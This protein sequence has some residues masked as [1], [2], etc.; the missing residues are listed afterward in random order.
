MPL[1]VPATCL[2]PFCRNSFV[3]NLTIELGQGGTAT[4]TGCT[5]RC[6]KCGK[7]AAIMNGVYSLYKTVNQIVAGVDT[8]VLNRA[9]DFLRS[10]QN[11]QQPTEVTKQ[12][13]NTE[14][15]ELKSLWDL[16]P[17]KRSEAYPLIGILITVIL[18]IITQCRAPKKDTP[19]TLALPDEI[20]NALK[21]AQTS[22]QSASQPKNHK[23]HSEGRRQRKGKR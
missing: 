18:F 3:A 10:Q 5:T 21:K 13:A 9:I 22:D 11:Q 4:L 8:Q 1:P 20:V 12:Q 2:N 6:P 19:S 23:P 16:F 17:K 7:S 14:V 15:P